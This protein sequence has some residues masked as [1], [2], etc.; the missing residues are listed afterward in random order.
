M[1]ILSFFLCV[2]GLHG[3][4]CPNAPLPP[5]P[6]GKSWNLVW[7]DEFDGSSLDKSK[8]SFRES[9]KRKEG[10]WSEKSV[11]LDGQ[12]HLVISAINDEGKFTTGCIH[13][14]GKFEQRYGLFV[15]RVRFQTQQGFWPAFWLQCKG[16]THVGDGGRDGT[17]IDIFEKPF[18]TDTIAHN[19]HWDGYGKNHQH[20]GFRATIPGVSK[21]WHTIAL[22]WTQDEYVFYVDG[23]ET[24]RNTGG[25]V[26]QVPEYIILSS[27][28]G[29]WAGD[30]TKAKLP[31]DVKFDYVRVYETVDTPAPKP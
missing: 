10:W 25:G 4:E 22:L 2:V 11:S 9:G 5:L 20:V 3:E 29:K 7:N 17:E 6:E 30:I 27:E 21:D 1:M 13:T 23:K 12:G 26:S 19:L 24:W 8:W 18:L 15:A 28:V 14:A 16:T 31:D